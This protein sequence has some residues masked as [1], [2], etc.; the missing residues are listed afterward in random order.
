MK[1]NI[2]YILFILLFL[3]GNQ[4][5]AQTYAP[6]TPGSGGPSA[7]TYAVSSVL[8]NGKWLK[9]RVSQS[10]LHRISFDVLR[11]N[12]IDPE[13]ARV[14]GYGGAMIAEDFSKPGIDDLPEVNSYVSDNSLIFYAQGPVS[15]EW[16]GTRFHH[17]TNPYSLY[18]YYFVT[19][20][21]GEGNR[22]VAET[23]PITNYEVSTN[24][25]LDY[26]LHELDS[27]NLI[28]RS[29]KAGGGRDF[30]GETLGDNH[31]L[32]LTFDFPN[33]IGEKNMSLMTH[34]AALSLEQSTFNLSLNG[35]QVQSMIIAKKPNDNYVRG[36]EGSRINNKILSDGNEKQVLTITYI[37]N[38]SSAFGFLDYVELSGYRQLKMVDDIL[39]FSCPEY[40]GSYSTKQYILSGASSD[41]RV[42]NITNPLKAYEMHSTLQGDQLTFAAD[43]TVIQQFVAINLSKAVIP[44][45]EVVGEVKNQDLH[46][47]QNIEYVVI[48]NE[49]FITQAQ[50]LAQA[51]AQYDGLTTAVLTDQEV[52]NEFSSG[53]PDASAYRRLMKMLYD[54]ANSNN[55]V[56]PRYLQLVGD[57]TFDN[58]KLLRTSGNNYL[59]TYQAINSTNETQAYSTDDYFCYLDDSNGT[60]LMS[61]TMDISVGR[62][63]VNS[64]SDAQGLVDKLI[65][66]I[67]NETFGNWKNQL[68]F[69]ADDGDNTAHVRCADTAAVIVAQNNPNFNINKIYLDAYQQEVSAS[70]ESYPLAKNKLENLLNKG[71]LFFNY[72][73]HAGYTNITNEIVLHVND[74]RKMENARQGFWLFATCNF[75]QYDAQT[76]SA[77]EESVLNPNG[78]AISMLSSC[79]TVYASD[80]EVLNRYICEALF[81]NKKNNPQY[82][83]TIGDAI[84]LGKNQQS[85]TENKLPYVLLG[86]PALRLHYPTDYK[87][88]VTHINGYDLS[89]QDTLRAISTNN[90]KGVITDAEGTM[91]DDF[92]GKIQITIFDKMQIVSTND[93]D[94]TDPAKVKIYQFKD[95]PNTLFN[96]EVDVVNGIWECT[97][98]MPKDIK[99]N[100]GLGHIVCYAYDMTNGY[101]ANGWCDNFVVGGSSDIIITD[102]EGPQITLYMENR[103]FQ[104]GGN[105][106]ERPHFY[107]DIYDENGINTVGSGIGHD[108]LLTIDS[109]PAQSY[110][111]NDYFTSENNSYQAGQISYRLST[112]SDGQHHLTLRAWDLLNNSSTAMLNFGVV[113]GL[114]PVIFSVVTYPNP[115]S[116]S[117]IVHFDVSHDRPDAVLYTQVDMY[118]MS[119][120]K[121]ASYSQQGADTISLNISDLNMSS[122]LYI[123]QIKIRTEQSEFV[124]NKGKLIVVN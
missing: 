79:R 16:T 84:R 93:N 90:I 57:G 5:Y 119:G 28:D 96:G 114:D 22:I 56:A 83:N 36:V 66:Y 74:I 7:K 82:D 70:G 101:E 9:V 81:A 59:L 2:R 94:Q 117:G 89:R 58:R 46:S 15:W 42:W 47:L 51:H 107:A 92:T 65:R 116:I 104:D 124:S 35:Q 55:G 29:G 32:R 85:Y 88:N 33:L 31:S 6:P 91:I 18:G 27:I 43:N 23:S 63:P 77:G 11:K 95:Y 121:V 106:N 108:L 3:S 78:G 54:R 123:Y 12:G 38:N 14:F 8:K 21:N 80:N 110:I 37:A 111:M 48:T 13:N 60:T 98:M 67:R 64:V 20:D 72:C 50:A 1:R 45:V 24:S 53:T 113:T 102:N 49:L 69:L 109:D 86:D 26:Q 17:T 115:V 30:Y 25:F 112:L 39:Y 71:V 68:L 122:G 10:G 19:S 99:Y 44:E 40:I 62:L 41:T 73:G 34:A 61:N 120:R 100:Y 97:F 87:V 76:V 118:D 4:L 105:V 103:E 75:S 52:Y